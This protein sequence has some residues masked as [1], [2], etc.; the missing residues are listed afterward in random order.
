MYKRLYFYAAELD[1]IALMNFINESNLYMFTNEA[2]L[3][4]DISFGNIR[5]DK[6]MW[7]LSLKHPDNV[8]RNRRDGITFTS[9]TYDVLAWRRGYVYK[10]HLVGNEIEQ[11]LPPFK[12]PNPSELDLIKFEDAWALRKIWNALRR[13]MKKN[14]EDPYANGDFFGP[15]A[16]RLLT[17]ENYLDVSYDPDRPPKFHTI[18][19]G[20]D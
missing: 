3:D 16:Y 6:R 20:D 14:W 5:N 4:E 9:A 18:Y 15:E 7:Y 19:V 17:E 8:R 10:N 1:Y 13:W 2:N 12:K 11:T